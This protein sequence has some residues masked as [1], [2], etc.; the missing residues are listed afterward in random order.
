MID[1]RETRIATCSITKPFLVANAPSGALD[2]KRSDY[3]DDGVGL[4]AVGRR[5]Y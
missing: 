2:P 5:S 3:S 1:S 4:N